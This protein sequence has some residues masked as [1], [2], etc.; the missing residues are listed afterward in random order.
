MRGLGN[1]RNE[2]A[3]YGTPSAPW[4]R[5]G[6]LSLRGLSPISQPTCASHSAITG[7]VKWLR[8]K[9][10]RQGI[11]PVTPFAHALPFL[12]IFSRFSP[13]ASSGLSEGRR[14]KPLRRGASLNNLKRRE[15]LA[16]RL[17]GKAVTKRNAS[18]RGGDCRCGL[19][20]SD[21][22]TRL[23]LGSAPSNYF[24]RTDSPNGWRLSGAAK[25]PLQPLVLRRPALRRT[26]G[27]APWVP[28]QVDQTPLP[29]P[30]KD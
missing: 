5:N 12:S 7:G 20:S 27:A 2:G 26:G 18:Y 14:G 28:G 10:S 11:R 8:C 1:R 6:G 17:G 29:C 3:F 13:A 15:V 22:S 19:P 16:I 23:R 21:L 30:A 24:R 25:R 4:L 9:R